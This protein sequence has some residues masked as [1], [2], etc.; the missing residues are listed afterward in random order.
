MKRTCLQ[1]VK[2][3]INSLICSFK[4]S[5]LLLTTYLNGS[6][7]WGHTRSGITAL[8]LKSNV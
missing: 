6:A 7:P 1:S 2:N 3:I 4:A 8:N 5:D